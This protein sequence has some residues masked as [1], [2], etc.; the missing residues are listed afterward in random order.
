M[1][2]ID[3]LYLQESAL[4]NAIADL[5]DQCDAQEEKGNILAAEQIDAAIIALSELKNEV[6]DKIDAWHSESAKRAA[7]GRL[8]YHVENDTLDLY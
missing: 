6:Q 3:K 1:E 4:H 5:C 7:Y 2:Y 8:A